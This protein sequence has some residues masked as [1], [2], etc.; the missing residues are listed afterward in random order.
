M[1]LPDSPLLRSK[2]KGKKLMGE[3]TIPDRIG[4]VIDRGRVK[5]RGRGVG[6]AKIDSGLIGMH[7]PPLLHLLGTTLLSLGKRLG[8]CS[9]DGLPPCLPNRPKPCLL[10]P[11]PP[12]PMLRRPG[13]PKFPSR[14][15]PIKVGTKA[16]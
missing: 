3:T 4:K 10:M 11:G 16:I 12:L 6:G 2:R 5:A 15:Q 13:W 7:R 9:L 1:K 8:L 14:F